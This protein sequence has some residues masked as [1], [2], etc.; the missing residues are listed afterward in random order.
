MPIYKTLEYYVNKANNI[1]D[2]KYDYS[3]IK[4]EGVMT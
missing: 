3:L 1:H 2:N 4:F